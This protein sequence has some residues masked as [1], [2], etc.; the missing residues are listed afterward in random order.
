MIILSSQAEY[1]NYAGCV[2]E[3]I[4]TASEAGCNRTYHRTLQPSNPASE[5]SLVSTP[6]I[7]IDPVVS[8]GYENSGFYPDPIC[9]TRFPARPWTMRDQLIHF[10]PWR[11]IIEDVCLYR[12]I[13]WSSGQIG[14][15]NLRYA[16]TGPGLYLAIR[17]DKL[18]RGEVN[19][20][21]LT[22]RNYHCIN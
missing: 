7:H 15:W 6:D 10:F 12:D 16:D 13:S 5:P 3:R 9:D 8:S 1:H 2:L 21:L 17:P 14:S 18:K 19:S 4:P 20:G 11:I 22:S